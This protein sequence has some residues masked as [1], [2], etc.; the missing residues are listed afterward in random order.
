MGVFYYRYLKV[1]RG[2][3]DIHRGE[4]NFGVVHIYYD[5][6]PAHAC[7]VPQSE[8]LGCFGFRIIDLD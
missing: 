6:S 4:G 3:L 2:V 8:G 7:D 1:E 5:F